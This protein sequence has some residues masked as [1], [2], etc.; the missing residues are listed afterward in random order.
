MWA[1]MVAD[2]LNVLVLPASGFGPPFARTSWDLSL[3]RVGQMRDPGF[4]PPE[5]GN[6]LL[7][8]QLGE[9]EVSASF[10]SQP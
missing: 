6:C 3:P 1:Q 8:S 9:A 10:V 2:R 5:C 4:E 7:V